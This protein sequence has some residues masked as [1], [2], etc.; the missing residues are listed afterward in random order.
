MYNFETFTSV[1]SSFASKV[2]IRKNGTIGFSQGA[3]IKFGLNVGKWFA[4]LKYDR[5]AK[6]IGIMLTKTETEDGAVRIQCRE[7]SGRDDKK[8]LAGQISAKAFLDFFGIEY[9]D[10][11]RAFIPVKDGDI[12]IID[13]NKEKGVPK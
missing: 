3:L 7:I 13:L 10:R 11:S 5:T 2:S 6:V 8:N 9:A 1:R 4:V 12:I